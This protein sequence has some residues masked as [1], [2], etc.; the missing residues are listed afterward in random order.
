MTIANQFIKSGY[1]KHVLVVGCEGLSKIVDWKDRNTCVLFGDGAGAAVLGPV[2][3]GYGIITTH[4]GADGV[5]GKNITMPCCYIGPEDIQVRSGDNKKVLW[6]DGSEVF[7]F[8][9]RIMEQATNKVLE[10]SGLSMED[11]KLIV[12]HQANIRIIEGAA[13]D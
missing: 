5:L 10:D 8:A 4:I 13:R 12:P 2:E 1:Y 11:I 3:E 6:M 9:V 7:K